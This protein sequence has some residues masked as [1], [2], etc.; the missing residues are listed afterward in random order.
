MGT[1]LGTQ[2]CTQLLYSK[3]RMLMGHGS[4]LKS[5]IHSFVGVVLGKTFSWG[6][7]PSLYFQPLMLCASI[8]SNDFFFLFF[9]FL[10]SN[11]K[12]RT[13]AIFVA[14]S[15]VFLQS[16][17]FH[18]MISTLKR[19]VCSKKDFCRINQ[20]NE[21]LLRLG[22]QF[23][24]IRNSSWCTE[25]GFH[26]F[27]TNPSRLFGQMGISIHSFFLIVLFFCFLL[28]FLLPIFSSFPTVVELF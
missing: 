6:S 1:R 14:Q 5:Q 22:R 24:S 12:I 4:C 19:Q 23:L 10:W 18:A 20:S 21:L 9:R 7:R 15:E 17:Y 13:C 3:K 27:G 2:L 16:I 8:T 25:N 11:N 26:P 28:F